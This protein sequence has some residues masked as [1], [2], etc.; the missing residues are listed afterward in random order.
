MTDS[1]QRKGASF[2]TGFEGTTMNKSIKMA[3]AALAVALATTVGLAAPADAKATQTQ[4]IH[5]CC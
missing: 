5:V 1:F 2:R 3:V 4:R